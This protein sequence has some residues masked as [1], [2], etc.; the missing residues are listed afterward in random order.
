M[1]PFIEQPLAPSLIAHATSCSAGFLRR[2]TGDD[3]LPSAMK[4]G[5]GRESAAAENRSREG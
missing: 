2:N 5:L 3:L 4:A 1:D